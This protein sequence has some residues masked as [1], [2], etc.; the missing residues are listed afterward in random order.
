MASVPRIGWTQAASRR[1]LRL[2][3][4]ALV[5]PILLGIGSSLVEGERWID[6]KL[7]IGCCPAAIVLVVTI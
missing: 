1:N 3:V 2:D 7:A 5:V 4:W 6:C